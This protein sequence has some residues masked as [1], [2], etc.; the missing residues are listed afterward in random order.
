MNLNQVTLPSL[1]LTISIP[2]YEKLGLQ[3]IVRALPHYARFECPDGD[4][5]FSL[6]LVDQLPKGTG[7]FIYFECEDLDKH[8]KRL[9]EQ[10][11]I[12]ELLPTD[13]P[14][15]WREARLFDPDHNHIILFKAGKDRKNPPWRLGA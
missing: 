12:F 4:S 2:F 15:R 13:Q 5:T 11:V 7:V 14:W 6:H 10:G 3:L 8:C 9:Q 1:D